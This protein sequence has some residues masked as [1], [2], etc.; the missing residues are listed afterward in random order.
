MLQA[1]RQWPAGLHLESIPDSVTECMPTTDG[2]HSFLDYRSSCDTR[3]NAEH[4]AE[5][6]AH[7]LALL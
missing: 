6:V 1:A 5:V 3:L 4:S 7:F 2:P